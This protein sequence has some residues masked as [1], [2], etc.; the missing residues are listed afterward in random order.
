[1]RLPPAWY[2]MRDT[3]AT[4]FPALAGSQVRQLTLWLTGTLVAGSGCES[5]VVLALAAATA[6]S[7][8]PVSA[9]TLRA[10]LRALFAEAAHTRTPQ[11]RARAH[12]LLPRSAR[13]CAALAAHAA[14]GA[15]ARCDHRSGSL[16]RARAQ[17]SLPPP[18]DPRRLDDPGGHRE[19]GSE[20]GGGRRGGWRSRGSCWPWRGCGQWRRGRWPTRRR[21]GCGVPRRHHRRGPG[22]G[23]CACSRAARR[24]SADAWGVARR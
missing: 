6:D 23:R 2:G 18:R 8:H 19:G 10:D 12:P 24:S 22:S 17:R 7:A 3:L 15:G 5:A 1:M 9:N 21:A 14:P 20:R 13:L 16:H 4:I 11:G